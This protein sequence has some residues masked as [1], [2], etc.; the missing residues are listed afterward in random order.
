MRLLKMYFLQHF[1]NVPACVC[2][3]QE[4]IGVKERTNL[5]R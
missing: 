3:F 2:V 5:E 1:I 4:K